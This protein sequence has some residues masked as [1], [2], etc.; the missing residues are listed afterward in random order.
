MAFTLNFP[1]LPPR[2][3]DKPS[4]RRYAL[5]RRDVWALY[6]PPE[7]SRRPR[8]G[9]WMALAGLAGC[10]ALLWTGWP[11]A[12]APHAPTVHWVHVRLA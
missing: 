12:A 1:N 11:S 7:G 4:F 8:I 10:I 5:R 2:S 9:R 6:A 3:P